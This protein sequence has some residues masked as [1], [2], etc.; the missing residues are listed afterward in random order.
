MLVFLV[1]LLVPPRRRGGSR[2]RRRI[3]AF[4]LA[5]LFTCLRR[6]TL[7]RRT[8]LL[9]GVFRRAFLAL[10][11]ALRLRGGARLQLFHRSPSTCLAFVVVADPAAEKCRVLAMFSL[12][13][14]APPTIVRSLER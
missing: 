10:P 9:R 13:N 2:R 12:A 4:V 1:P 8:S 6:R 14:T 11:T 5:R 3:L 7:W